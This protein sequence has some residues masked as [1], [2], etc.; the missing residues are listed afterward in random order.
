MEVIWGGSFEKYFPIFFKKLGGSE[1]QEKVVLK[2]GV[3]ITE[4]K[5]IE[6]ATFLLTETFSVTLN[7]G[8]IF[9]VAFHQE[10]LIKAL[11]TDPNFYFSV[12]QEFCIIFDVMYEKTGTESF[13]WSVTKRRDGWR[14]KFGSAC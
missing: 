13:L 11:Y 14:T 2:E 5:V 1:K 6:P 10:K 12:G 8:R 3:F 4:L 7:D 9:Q